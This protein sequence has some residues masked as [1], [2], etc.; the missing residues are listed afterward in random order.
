LDIYLNGINA[1]LSDLKRK[2]IKVKSSIVFFALFFHILLIVANA[3]QAF[4]YPSQ[5]ILD[6]S[7]DS[8]IDFKN[9]YTPFGLEQELE[10]SHYSGEMD[11]LVQFDLSL[12][13]GVIVESAYLRLYVYYQ[14]GD[15]PPANI[16][17]GRVTDSW[18]ETT[19]TW[20]NRPSWT[21]LNYISGPSSIGSWWV[22]DVASY[23]NNWVSGS[24]NNY[25][26]V[27]GAD[28]PNDNYFLMCSKEY[29]CSLVR[30][31]LELN[32]HNVSV[33]PT[34]LGVLKAIYK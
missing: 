34:S 20:D 13:S 33:Q 9:P 30:P 19:I 22:I 29:L 3:N 25:G 6:A 21:E 11:S 17:I 5:I 18:D 12:Y 4:F 2:V 27:L 23:V 8:I 31:Q 16:W 28:D 1:S 15:F 32:Y 24:Y 26:F 7:Q 14:Y 10:I